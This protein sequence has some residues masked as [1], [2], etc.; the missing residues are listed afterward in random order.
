ME[1]GSG[2]PVYPRRHPDLKPRAP[3]RL[4]GLHNCNTR[5]GKYLP[6]KEH[7]KAGIFPESPL[8][9]PFL[10]LSSDA[11][12]VVFPHNNQILARMVGRHPDVRDP[13]SMPDRVV[14]PA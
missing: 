11:N 6:Y 13:L 7:P 3:A 2:N 4:P 10:F 5:Q 1:L 14:I 9:D 8:E 12:P